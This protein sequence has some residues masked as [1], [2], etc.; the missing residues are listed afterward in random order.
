MRAKRAANPKTDSHMLIQKPINST[1]PLSHS[2]TRSELHEVI[3]SMIGVLGMLIQFPLG[4]FAGLS[5][6]EAEEEG[7][8][9]G[10]HSHTQ[11][12]LSREPIVCSRSEAAIVAYIFPN[13]GA[14]GRRGRERDR[15]GTQ[16]YMLGACA[17]GI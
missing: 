14:L 6:E 13:A 11:V 9:D 2:L 1:L 8:A 16:G 10:G 12:K 3:G 5:R 7:K 4:F 17:Q 15:A